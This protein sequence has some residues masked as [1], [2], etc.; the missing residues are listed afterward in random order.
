MWYR[1]TVALVSAVLAIAANAEP[2][3]VA[4]DS[5]HPT[6]IESFESYPTG[7]AASSTFAGFS[8]SFGESALPWV[9]SGYYCSS[10]CLVE[11]HLIEPTPRTLTT[12]TPGTTQVGLAVDSFWRLGFPPPRS[13]PPDTFLVRVVGNSGTLEFNVALTDKEW[14]AFEDRAGLIEVSFVNNGHEGGSWNYSFDDVVTSAPVPEPGSAFL[15]ASGL[16]AVFS[17]RRCSGARRVA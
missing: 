16:L 13:D 14:F 7:P 17:L 8:I 15:I 4:Y 5:I 6:S 10:K 1:R 11:N 3:Q 9:Y 2:R 12:F